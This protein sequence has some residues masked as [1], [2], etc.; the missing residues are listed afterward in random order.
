MTP[1]W[2]RPRRPADRAFR[3]R[4][5]S[6]CWAAR[7]RPAT[8]LLSATLSGLGAA[9]EPLLYGKQTVSHLV[10]ALDPAHAGCWCSPSP[11]DNLQLRPGDRR[12]VAYLSSL[13]NLKFSATQCALLSS[14][15]L[16]AAASGRRLFRGHG[17]RRLPCLVLPRHRAFGIP[18]L[19]LI[20]LQ[21]AR[22]PRANNDKPT[23]AKHSPNDRGRAIAGLCVS[24]AD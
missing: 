4:C 14:I 10:W 16:L 18:T 11:L 17:E 19:L 5:R 12:L 8:N 3:H 9:A 7:P 15:M 22:T 24:I 21:W 23:P 13:T 6:C 1:A 2:R 20:V